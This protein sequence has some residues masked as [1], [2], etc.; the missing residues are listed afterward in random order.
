MSAA[1]ASTTSYSVYTSVRIAAGAKS[2]LVDTSLRQ[3]QQQQGSMYTACMTP[4]LQR[5]VVAQYAVHIEVFE[6]FCGGCTTLM[7]NTKKCNH[8]RPC[9]TGLCSCCRQHNK[10]HLAVR[11][12][13]ASKQ[14]VMHQA[15][16]MP[17]MQLH[18][19]ML[20]IT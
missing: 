14:H 2:V 8:I 18:E 11:S 17:A 9:K 15:C 1:V 10:L 20:C 12:S 16:S 4:L 6:F 5:Y 13:G 7:A 19:V 3:Q